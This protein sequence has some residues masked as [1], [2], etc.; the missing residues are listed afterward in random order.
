MFFPLFCYYLGRNIGRARGASEM[1]ERVGLEMFDSV[2]E[3]QDRLYE[4][5]Q[6]IPSQAEVERSIIALAKTSAG[7]PNAEVFD[8]MVEEVRDSAE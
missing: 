4:S 2:E 8:V 7:K 1:S 5:R 3:V 6:R